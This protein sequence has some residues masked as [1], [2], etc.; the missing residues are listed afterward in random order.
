MVSIHMIG[1]GMSRG[2]ALARQHGFIPPNKLSWIAEQKKRPK[3]QP[4][5]QQPEQK[6][7]IDYINRLIVFPSD[8]FR[9][10]IIYR[11]IDPSNPNEKPDISSLF[12]NEEYRQKGFHEGKLFSENIF[13]DEPYLKQLIQG[14]RYYRESSWFEIH[15]ATCSPLDIATLYEDSSDVYQLLSEENDCDVLFNAAFIAV[16]TLKDDSLDKLEDILV[17]IKNKCKKRE[18]KQNLSALKRVAQKFNRPAAQVIQD[19]FPK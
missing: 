10:D 17:T 2:P 19:I 7:R 5:K 15:P 6:K 16:S 4:P 3:Q 14:A 8:V 12:L 18:I 13:F 9:Y 1:F 11:V